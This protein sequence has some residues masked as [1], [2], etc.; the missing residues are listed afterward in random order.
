MFSHARKGFLARAH[1]ADYNRVSAGDW[2]RRGW[3]GGA[4]GEVGL[5]IVVRGRVQGVWYRA[6]TMREAEALGLRGWVRNRADGSVEAALFGEESAVRA[7][8]E[9]CR[10]GP[11][12]ARVEAV[13]ELPEPGPAPDGFRQAPTV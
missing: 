5:R 8:V 3:A 4:M 10:V 12:A 11:P 6:W 2:S 13:E 7:M 9:R 1:P